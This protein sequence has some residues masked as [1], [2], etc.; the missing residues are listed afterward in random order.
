MEKKKMFKIVFISF[1]ILI[2][3]GI[4]VIL[5]LNKKEKEEENVITE[6]YTPAEEIT[7]EQVRQTII[8]L[9]YKQKE[10]NT[11]MPEARL[12]DVKLLAENP[13][14]TLINLLIAEPK[15]DKLESCIA[16]GTTVKSA[17]IKNDVVYVD[18]SSEFIE[19]HPGGE[20]QEKQTIDAIVNTL[21]ELNEVKAVR[22]L[23][24]GE[25]NLGFHDNGINFEENF[26]R[27]E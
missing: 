9:Y 27:N 18:F 3:I 17:Q 10:T 20:E 16:T 24:N 26:I 8:T 14:L 1:I 5:F 23:I 2:L 15:S 25:E 22:I 6:E 12:I 4:I 11:L 21:T 13:Y 7:D 19:N